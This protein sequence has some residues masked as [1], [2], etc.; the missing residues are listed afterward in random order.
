ME[1]NTANAMKIRNI[2]VHF[3][4]K[5]G[6][7]DGSNNV[8]IIKGY[9]Y[10]NEIYKDGISITAKINK[11]GGKSQD[12]ANITIYGLLYRD[13]ALLSTI[14]FRPMQVVKNRVRVY[15]GY[16]NNLSLVFEGDIIKAAASFSDVNEPFLVEA[17]SSYFNQIKLNENINIKGK[18]NA[19]KVFETLAKQT[20]L[21]YKNID[22]NDEL[23]NPVLMGGSTDQIYNLGKKLGIQTKIDNGTLIVAKKNTPFSKSIFKISSQSG[24]LEYPRLD[25]KGISFRV[26]Y[27]PNLHFGGV[28]DISSIVPKATG[29]WKIYSLEFLLENYHEKFEINIKASYLKSS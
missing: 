4:L 28:V 13:I 5:K 17:Q 20:G 8:K 9:S 7:F 12:K 10:N 21:T 16:E 3:A 29:L 11:E 1:N 14:N 26:R 19:S 22:I 15:V 24:L 6:T 18:I 2:E 27:N 25:E 23:D